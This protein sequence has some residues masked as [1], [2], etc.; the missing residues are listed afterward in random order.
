MWESL[1]NI[2]TQKMLPTYVCGHKKPIKLDDRKKFNFK[3][4]GIGIEKVCKQVRD[5][6]SMETSYKVGAQ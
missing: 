6:K 3:K 1:S 2:T 4:R 5:Q